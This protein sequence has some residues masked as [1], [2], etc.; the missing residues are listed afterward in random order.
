MTHRVSVSFVPS[1]GTGAA[2]AAAPEDGATEGARPTHIEGTAFAVG[3]PSG[4]SADGFAYQFAGLPDNA[5]DLIDVVNEH[6]GW[7][8]PIGRLAAPFALGEDGQLVPARVRIF[9]TQAGRDVLTLAA[10]GVKGGFSVSAAFDSFDQDESGVRHVNSWSAVH[11][12]VVRHPAFTESRGLTLAASAASTTERTTMPPEA[13]P[14]V[15][16]LPTVAELSA[17][18]A[19][20]LRAANAQPVHP[21]AQFSSAAAF[22]AAF[23]EGSEDD[24]LRMAAEFAL[25]SQITT[26]NPGVMLP[27]WRQEIQWNLDARRPAVAAFGTTGLP[28]SGMTSSWPY[29]DTDL[30]GII[31]EQVTQLTQLTGVRLDIKQGTANIKSAGIASEV[32]YQLLL[33]SSPAYMAAHNQITSAAWYR[34]TEAVF[35]A[36]ITAASTELGTGSTLPAIAAGAKPTA[37]N[38]K[39]FEASMAV[40]D[41]TGAPAEFVLCSDTVFKELGAADLPNPENSNGGG[42]PNANGQASASKLRV[43]VNGLEHYRAPFLT[44]A[45]VIVSNSSAAKFPESGAMVATQDQVTKLGQEVATWGMYVPAEV[46]F[47]AGVVR[48]DR[49]V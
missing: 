15:V 49:T 24:R 46:Y 37:F 47:P 7:A 1:S 39:I 12:G 41:A 19:E 27:T 8:D 14:P 13:L 42:T 6:D 30:D 2:F 40:E 11:L 45:Q 22:F 32:S 36:A 28:E 34:Y 4:A 44:G 5:E 43:N 38:G 26:N 33:R 23:R 10:E 29:F 21:L 48:L 25:G 20:H 17:Q 31:A 16:E 9:D 18:V 3:T 35:E